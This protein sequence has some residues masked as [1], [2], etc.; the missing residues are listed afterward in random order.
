MLIPNAHRSRTPTSCCTA[1]HGLRHS[2]S[3]LL[4]RACRP[5][6]PGKTRECLDQ[7]LA[8]V[9]SQHLVHDERQHRATKH[10]LHQTESSWTSA[11]DDAVQSLCDWE[12]ATCRPSVLPAADRPS[13]ELVASR[14]RAG[15]RS[16]PLQLQ[17]P[18]STPLHPRASWRHAALLGCAT[19]SRGRRVRAHPR[20]WCARA[21][22][23][24]DAV[25]PVDCAP[26]PRLVVTH[27]TRRLRHTTSRPQ[28]AGAPT[29]LACAGAPTVLACSFSNLPSRHRP[30]PPGS[31]PRSRGAAQ[32]I[33]C[34]HTHQ[35]PSCLYL[36]S[37]LTRSMSRTT[38]FTIVFWSHKDRQAQDPGPVLIMRCSPSKKGSRNCSDEYS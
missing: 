24:P 20:Y 18:R 8:S 10:Q 30:C 35:H 28:S 19:H 22:T 27:S 6:L 31:T 15:P 14:V 34:G 12:G 23:V 5:H 32:R 13:P 38:L 26:P 4:R 21:Q 7:W 3:W 16:S 11:S 25:S 36:P 37:A 33:A 2:S 1:W 9:Q 17:P 29:V